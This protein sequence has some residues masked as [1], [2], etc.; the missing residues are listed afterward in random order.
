MQLRRLNSFVLAA[1]YEAAELPV[2]NDS[3][4]GLAAEEIVKLIVQLP[5]GYRTVFNLFEVEGY[6][7][8]EI[9]TLLNI[10]EG[11]SKSQLSKARTLL[12][13]MWLQQNKTHESRKIN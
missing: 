10:T 9:A 4:A 11:T 13:K 2:V 8:R 5:A 6:S 7:H 12:Q 1:E 3:I